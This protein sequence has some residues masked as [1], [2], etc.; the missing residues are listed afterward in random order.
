M[1]EWVDRSWPGTGIMIG[2][3]SFGGETHMSGALATAE[4]LGRFAEY[5][6]DAAFYWT[7]PPPESPAAFAFRAYRDFDGHGARF[8]DYFI[9][10]T[11][12]PGTSVFASRDESGKR[13]VLVALNLS[14]ANEVVASIDF[15]ACG[16]PG[17]IVAR[18]FTGQRPGF[19][20]I[21]AAVAAGYLHLILPA[22][23]ITVLDLHLTSPLQA[24]VE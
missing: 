23:S 24:S 12:T 5:G 15:S 21:P 9:P 3:W 13:V 7:V 22:Y 2:E 4:A 6:V 10:S 8:G 11:A 17:Q 14:P 1:R 19:M 16:S 18:S 20:P